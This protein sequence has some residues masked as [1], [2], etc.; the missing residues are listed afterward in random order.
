MTK[1]PGDDSSKTTTATTTTKKTTTE[2]TNQHSNEASRSASKQPSKRKHVTRH[3]KQ[4]TGTQNKQL[5]ARSL[6]MTSD[7]GLVSNCIPAFVLAVFVERL[8]DFC[9][10]VTM[11]FALVLHYCR[12]GQK[13]TGKMKSHHSTG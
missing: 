10:G 2:T 13:N 5:A 3:D 8:H 6:N 11:C 4:T 12:P 1:K 7:R 9:S